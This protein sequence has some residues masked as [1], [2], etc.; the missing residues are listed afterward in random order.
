MK[1]LQ[2]DLLV[3]KGWV[4]SSTNFDCDQC[5]S[6]ELT[7][8]DIKRM[9]EKIE[10]M[11]EQVI[12]LRTENESLKFTLANIAD[13]DKRVSFYTGFPMYAALMACFKF[14][15]PVV[16]ELIYWNSKL[17]DTSEMKKKGRS[18]TLALIQEFF[19]C[20]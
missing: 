17:H 20:C 5:C 18:R 4:G 7:I 12:E 14:L 9:D 2:I 16:S 11:K 15:G 10:E 19:L 6:T 13:N 1:T 8:V 3:M